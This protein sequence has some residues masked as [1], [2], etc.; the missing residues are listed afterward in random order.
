M[1]PSGVISCLTRA[2]VPRSAL[3]LYNE[4]G[5]VL[6]GASPT[7]SALPGVTPDRGRAASG[8]ALWASLQRLAGSR[9]KTRCPF[10][11]RAL[12]ICISRQRQTYIDLLVTQAASAVR[13]GCHLARTGRWQWVPFASVEDLPCRWALQRC[14]QTFG[15]SM[16]PDLQRRTRPRHDTSLLDDGSWATVAAL[17]GVRVAEEADAA[18]ADLSDL[19]ALSRSDGITPRDRMTNYER[20][21][22]RSRELRCRVRRHREP[23]GG[24]VRVLVSEISG[25]A[26]HWHVQSSYTDA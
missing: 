7:S 22:A 2:K 23:A 4:F 21:L 20:M 19:A 26:P 17:S 25:R 15:S 8:R 10:V 16:K 9:G 3:L 5:E 1:V 13:L 6:V 11:G 12:E 24:E 18:A 14:W